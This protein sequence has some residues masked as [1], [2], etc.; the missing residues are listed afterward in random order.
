MSADQVLDWSNDFM[1]ANPDFNIVVTGSSAGKGFQSL[2]DKVAEVGLASR[3]INTN[4]KKAAEEKNLKLDHKNIGYSAVAVVTS[5]NNPINELTI[6]QLRRIYTGQV[7]NW[8]DVGG[9]DSPIRA[10]SR[11]IPESGGAVFF[12]ELVMG[13]EPFGSNVTF[14]ESWQSIL[15]VCSLAKD[16]PIGIAPAYI[17]KNVKTIAVKKDDSSPA[18]KPT[19]DQVNSKTYPIILQFAMW[20]DVKE[21]DD[22]LMKY[23]DFCAAKGQ[24]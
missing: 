16:M 15:K 4:E 10:F 3:D 7:T 18:I 2:F 22:K 13:K 6:D 21:K 24:E 11:R 8:K 23:I 5:Q 1:K 14:A 19:P 20:W 12:W 9:A 17:T